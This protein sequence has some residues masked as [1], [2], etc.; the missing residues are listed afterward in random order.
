MKLVIV[1]PGAIGMLWYY[2]LSALSDNT[3]LMRASPLTQKF[4][5]SFSFTDINNNQQQQTL[6]YA[7]D[8][9]IRQADVLLFTVKSYQVSA[10]VAAIQH[11]V[12]SKSILILCHNGMGTL[13][14][15]PQK[16]LTNNPI[17]A[18]L[19]TQGSMKK[20][21]TAVIH[22][23]DGQSYIGITSGKL[24]E[25]N[26]NALINLLNAALPSVTFHDDIIEKQWLKL[27]INCVINPLTAINRHKNGD[28][29]KN[30]YQRIIKHILA[31]VVVVAA[32]EKVSLSLSDLEKTVKEVALLTAKNTSSMLS[33]VLKKQKTEID[34]INGYIHQLGL[35]HHI[36]TPENT[37]LWQ[38]VSAL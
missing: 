24:L 5:S 35:K 4:P 33:D 13:T 9:D 36:A 21:A 32:Q 18:M 31:E 38:Q 22:T 23:G 30:K 29:N 15:I 34:Y 14:D 20:S 10:A 27:A 6:F 26:I 8:E 28:I 16:L 7:S 3:V 1:G 19:T 12:P 11:L 2:H 25:T 37:Q 17:M